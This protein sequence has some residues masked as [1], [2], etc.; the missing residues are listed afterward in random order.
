MNYKKNFFFF[1]F[2][3]SSCVW[4]QSSSSSRTSSKRP[5]LL[6]KKSEAEVAHRFSLAEWL[7]TKNRNNTMDMWLGYNTND[8]IYEFKL[9]LNMNQDDV[10]TQVGG[11]IPA[12]SGI[13]RSYEGELSAYARNVGL[14]AGYHDNNE[15][16][17]T[18]TTG[19]FNFR[20]FGKSMQT[21]H[22][23]LHYGLRTRLGSGSASY[24]LNQQFPA[25]TFQLYIVDNFG[26]YSHYRKYLKSNEA[27]FGDT[28][29]SDLQYGVF[30][31]YG[32]LRIFGN[33]FEENQNSILNNVNTDI[34]HKG[35]QFGIQLY[36]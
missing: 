19:M 3:I 9:G 4:A 15:Q 35:T 18:D 22:L 23:T 7:D 12:A 11:G 30:I 13:F 10:K 20:L 6:S 16:N 24:R 21:S 32:R 34:N 2:F 5:W 33:M 27:V 28:E 1:V 25:A 26:I 36:W 8:D 17:F 14:T 29:G 31:E